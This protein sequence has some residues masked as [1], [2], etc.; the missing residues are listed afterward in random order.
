MKKK[1]DIIE[2]DDLA[3]YEPVNS[4]FRENMLM[5]WRMEDKSHEECGLQCKSRNKKHANRK[6][7]PLLQP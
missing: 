3:I 5:K 2:D 6:R 7:A 1:H 4:Q